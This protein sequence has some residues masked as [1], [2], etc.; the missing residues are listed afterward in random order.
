V[1]QVAFDDDSGGRQRE[2]TT[3]AWIRTALAAA[4][5]GLL[6]ER[7]TETEGERWLVVVGTMIG[8]I[9]FV[10]V[11]W[12]RT[13]RLRHARSPAAFGPVSSIVVVMSLLLLNVAGLFVVL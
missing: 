3:L 11:A 4:A 10:V 9:G 5:V 7:L 6:T 12:L 8:V 13:Q 2:R 1:N